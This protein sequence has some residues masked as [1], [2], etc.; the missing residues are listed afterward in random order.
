MFTLVTGDLGIV[1]RW[2]AVCVTALQR[3]NSDAA[4][5]R[6]VV[7][8]AAASLSVTRCQRYIIIVLITQQRE[9]WQDSALDPGRQSMKKDKEGEEKWKRRGL[10][11]ILG[12]PRRPSRQDSNAISRALQM[13][14]HPKH[15]STSS[16]SSPEPAESR[17]RSSGGSVD[18]HDSSFSPFSSPPANSALGVSS[19]DGSKELDGAAM[20]VSTEGSTDSCDGGSRTSGSLF[21]FPPSPLDLLQEEVKDSDRYCY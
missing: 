16:S 19:P 10:S 15:L 20:K 12:P 11:S 9:Q 2:R 13:Q 5:I 14:K 6:I 18:G 8:I 4:A 3:P 1:G 7:G 17:L 21:D